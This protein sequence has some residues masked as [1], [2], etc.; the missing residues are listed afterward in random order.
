MSKLGLTSVTLLGVN[1]IIGSG[2]FLLP[3][4]LY[5]AAGDWSVIIVIITALVASTIALCFAEAASYFSKNG[6][7]Y[8]YA[9]EAFGPFVGFEVGFLKWIMQCI[10]WAVMVVALSNILSSAF[11]FEDNSFLK[12]VIEVTIIV[13]LTVMNLLGVSFAK[14][15]NNI[16]T[17]FKVIPLV[18]FIVGGIAFVHIH[19]VTPTLYEHV[20]SHNGTT[21]E[22][23]SW[24]NLASAIVLCFYAYTGFETFSTAAEDMDNPRRNLPRAIVATLIIVPAFYA[25]VVFVA[26]G[27]LGPN[28]SNSN[29]PIADAARVFMG[30][31]GYL[32]VTI[33]SIVSIL[34][35]NI[36]ASFHIPRALLPLSDDNIIPAWFAWKTNRKSIPWV[37]ILASGIVT[38]PIAL[39]GSF[40]TLAVLSVVTRF[41]QYIPTCLAIFVFRRRFANDNVGGFKVPFGPLIPVLGVAVC[42]WMMSVQSPMKLIVGLLVILAISPLYIMSRKQGKS[43]VDASPIENINK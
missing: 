37:A 41:I 15:I 7:A 34:G 25:L 23:M 24:S 38:I 11:N 27:I 42:I 28:I 16:S 29:M 6:A 30:G 18:I 43:T 5:K 9:R 17:C 31:Y 33:G 19:N 1:S 12:K 10:A 40:A 4:P 2:I 26:V 20:L 36:A 32:L 22:G 8:V 14:T 21:E 35:I 3:T 39:S 13:L